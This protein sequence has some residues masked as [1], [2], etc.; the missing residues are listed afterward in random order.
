MAALARNRITFVWLGLSVITLVSW[1]I[2]AK[3]GAE[4]FARSDIVTFSVILLAA[5]KIRFI[6]REFMEVRTAPLVLRR[7]TDGVVLL[8][9]GGLLTIYASGLGIH[10]G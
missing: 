7:L 8:M 4:A 2:G 1:W 3:H 9:A 10:L 6:L 5:T